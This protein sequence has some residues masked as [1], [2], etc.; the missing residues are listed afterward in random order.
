MKLRFLSVFL[1]TFCFFSCVLLRAEQVVETDWLKIEAPEKAVPG[2]PFEVKVTPKK[3]PDGL[4]IGGDLHW[5]QKGNYLGFQSWG[6]NPKPAK[7]GE[8]LV[9]RYRMADYES[10]E[11]GVQPI[12]FLTTNGWNEATLKAFGPV[13]LPE[14]ND[15]IRATLRPKT[16]TFRKSWLVLGEPQ[17]A[18]GGKPVWKSGEKIVIPGE[19]YVDPSDDWGKTTLS[20]WVMGPWIDCPDGKYE[21]K[22]G[23]KSGRCGIRD[24]ECE[25]GKRVKTQWELTLPKAYA[26]ESPEKGKM[27]DQLLLVGQFKGR[28][29]KNWP[30]QTRRGL[31]AFEGVGDCFTLDALTPGNLFTYDEPVVMN[32]RATE[33][34]QTLQ[35]AKLRWTVQNIAGKTLL[36]G[37]ED[38]P[39]KDGKTLEIPLKLSEKGTFL[40][41]A[42]IEGKDARETTFARIPNLKEIV[43]DGPTPFGGQKFFGDEEAAKAARRLG[44][45]LC[46]VWIQWKDFEPQRGVFNE[47]AFQETR[48]KLAVLRRNHIKPWL[49]FDG[50]P[51]WA[52]QNPAS[53][54]GQFKAF[55]VLDVDV[56][57][58]ISRLTKEFGNEILGFEWQNEIVPGD[59]CEDPVA[60]YLRFCK[61]ADAASK[62]VNPKLRNQL[63][64]GLWPQSFRQNL[65]GAGVAEFIDILP[66]HYGT[67]SAVRAAQRDLASAGVDSRVA[68]WDNESAKGVSTWGMPLSEALKQ[69]EQSD[70]YFTRFPDELL[71]G[72]EKIVLFGGEASASGDWSPFWAD[73]SPRPSAAAFAVLAH[74]LADAEPVGEFSVGKNDSLKLFDRPKR[75]PILVVSS[76]E[77][78]GETVRL[79]VGN[80]TKVRKIDQQ[81]NETELKNAGGFVTLDLTESPYF[82]EGGDPDVL[83]AQLVLSFPGTASG[84]PT[85]TAVVGQTLEIPL[86]LTNG[87]KR[88]VAGSVALDSAKSS[89]ASAK[90]S[91]ESVAFKKLKAG[92]SRSVILKLADVK[93][94][95]AQKVVTLKFSD[96]A[97]P[98]ISRRIVINAVKPE[99]IGNLLKNPGFE[100]ADGQNADA[101]ADWNGSGKPGKRVPHTD[102]SALG[103]GGF[104][105]RFENT[106]GGYEHIS[107][108]IPKLPTVGGVY[109]YSFW[110][111]SENLTTGSNLGGKTRDGKEWTWHW[112][113]VLQAP[114]NQPTW[115][116]ISKR[117]EL[118]AETVSLSPTPVCQGDGWTEIDNAQ[119]VPFEGTDF[120]AFA[121]RAGKI[122]IDGNLNDFQKSAPIPLLGENQVKT[123]DPAYV[124]T[125]QNAS[126]VAYFNYDANFLYVGVEVLDDRHV[127]EKTGE[128]CAEQDSIRVAIHPM[129]RL[130]GEES[131]AFCFDLSSA[132]PG[133]SGKH[134]LFRPAEYSGGLK[135]G[136]L[137]K[138]SSVYDLVVK[139]DGNCTVYE[140]AMPWSDLGGPAGII[141]TKIGL[142]LR[143]TD[144]DGSKPA[145]YLL[146]GEG[147]QPAW[148]PASF[149]VLTLTE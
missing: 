77:K 130:P 85:F 81:G 128:Q 56:E 6:G 40:F 145:A 138:D 103:H 117:L 10:D 22:R 95:T 76:I 63:A 82:V 53:Y 45:S 123:L 41:H 29:K 68:V 58:I 47:A 38:F 99:E 70:Y 79:A 140:L 136:S 129:N 4:K 1:L 105:H 111:R 110:V 5:S 134:T 23:H 11:K 91:T 132:A 71:A 49:L 21:T 28:D 143:L 27:G 50:F 86:R 14:M 67:G 8:T 131:R 55:P 46:R 42:E 59:A 122:S 64:G 113:Q 62:K 108:N 97:L 36:S 51:V 107:Q 37:S 124:W 19:Y 149:G 146:W 3:I 101:A 17:S 120:A 133:G 112:L 118:P 57:R 72:C 31:P 121:P 39:P 109:V 12:Y 106:K 144:C 61:V 32:V 114:K 26:D 52:I 141:G 100:L 30:W 148:S 139:R 69:T 34:G 102:S 43:G 126:A 9:F 125:P 87:L 54:G 75:G 92:K 18:D 84:T 44:M 94:G 89:P 2:Q 116:V 65:L 74:A 48:E 78:G 135:S 115:R 7:S 80:G 15:E 137:A 119:L 35:N 147:L 88:E 60:D 142:S 93:P 127:A 96:P 33:K 66:V 83:R 90:D 16:A 98:A 24:T 104:V 20:I 25:V 73:H 13:I